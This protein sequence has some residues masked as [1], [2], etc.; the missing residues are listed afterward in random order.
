M[1]SGSATEVPPNFWTTTNRG[2]Y[3][4]KLGSPRH[5][6]GSPILI[7]VSRRDQSIVVTPLVDDFLKPAIEFMRFC[8]LAI[9]SC[10]GFFG[11]V[12]EGNPPFSHRENP[13]SVAL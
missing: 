7:V 5:R 12:R 6:R 4:E 11:F 9:E 8:A 1:A 10:D 3:T 2:F 13:R